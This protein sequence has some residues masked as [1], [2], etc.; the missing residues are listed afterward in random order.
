ML[1]AHKKDLD[2]K[3]HQQVEE[4][5]KTN[6]KTRTDEVLDSAVKAR[7]EM[8]VSSRILGDL[9]KQS[10]DL[11]AE[12][13]RF[14]EKLASLEKQVEGK[15]TE[16][17]SRLDRI[18]SDFLGPEGQWNQ[19]IREQEFLNKSRSYAAKLA[20]TLPEPRIVFREDRTAPGTVLATYDT[21]ENVYV[22]SPS[23]LD[24][25]GLPEYAALMGRFFEKNRDVLNN[26]GKPGFPDI[27]LWQNFR[28]SIVNYLL[29]KDG[30][31]STPQ[32]PPNQLDFYQTLMA[33]EKKADV[34]SIHKLATALLEAFGQDW[35]TANFL[36]KVLTVNEKVKALPAEEVKKAFTETPT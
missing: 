20:L 30:F 35:N 24:T 2:G 25:P 4:N 6:Y 29:V 9:Q 3:I 23:K 13:N 10:K 15:A 19:R 26:V 5:L 11:E 14:H 33:M 17:T 31:Q 8:T 16:F 27:N 22:I 36:E 7:T 12:L 21:K 32:A 18:T 1:E 34:A 28:Q